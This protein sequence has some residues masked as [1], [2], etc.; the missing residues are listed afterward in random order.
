MEGILIDPA[1]DEEELLR[2]LQQKGIKLVYIVNTHGHAD[3]TCGNERLRKET[4]AKVVLHKVDD[5]FY[6]K[7]ANQNFARMMGFLRGTRCSWVR[8][9]GPICRAVRSTSSLRL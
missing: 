6:Q 9:A 2:H 1:G 5:V 7:P 4:G 8:W 3:H